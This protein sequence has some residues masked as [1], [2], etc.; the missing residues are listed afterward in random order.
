[1]SITRIGGRA[2]PPLLVKGF[3]TWLAYA[4]SGLVS[5]L[6]SRPS[7]IVIPLYLPAGF[8]LACVL[9]WGRWMVVPVGLGAATVMLLASGLPASPWPSWHVLVIM[10]FATCT[11]AGLQAWV[12]ARW[13]GVAPGAPLRLESPREI[14]RFM[15]L[16]GALACF[17]NA[18]IVT[19][20]QAIVSNM[21][22][23]DA[24]TMAASWWAGDALGV[25][26]GAPLML[27]LVG[28][29]A[30]LWRGRQR[31]VGIPLLVIT[32]LLGWTIREV[33]NWERERENSVFSRDTQS[34]GANVKA[35]LNGYLYALEALHGAA[36]SSDAITRQEFHTLSQFWLTSLAGVQAVGWSE[37]VAM[38]DLPAFER[39]QQASG[40]RQY[41][42]FN[43]P[44][45][46][47]PRDE[48]VA[49]RYIEPVS[50]NGAALGYNILSNQVARSTYEAARISDAPV[51]SPGLKLIQEIGQQTGVVLYK[52]VHAGQ[53][54]TTEEM[55]QSTKGVMFLTLRMD[56]M[57]KAS[58]AGHPAYLHTCVVDMTDQQVLGGESGCPGK[59]APNGR[60]PQHL[61][62]IDLTFANRPWHLVVWTNERPPLI[63]NLSWSWLV[64]V[65][66]VT[67]A[68]AL[69]S[70]LLVITGRTKRVEEAMAQA[71]QL[72]IAA[73]SANRAKSEFLSRMSH[74]LRTPLNA[75][76]GFA[77]VME[78]DQQTPLPAS[79]HNRL[80]QIQQAGWHLL[81]MIDDVLDLSRIDTGTIKL[82]PEEVAPDEVIESAVQM[83]QDAAQ[84][85]LVKIMPRKPGPAGWGI[86]ADRTR[87]RQ[88]LIN[89]LGNAIKYNRPNGLITISTSLDKA[90]DGSARYHMT[91]TDTGLGMS[92]AQQAQLFQPFNRL[93]REKMSADGVGIGLVISQHLA[94]MM[95]GDLS[96]HSVEG[97][98]SS[99]T[100][101]LPASALLPLTTEN[102]AMAP[103]LPAEAST[104]AAPPRA[105][106]EVL[107]VEDNP[108]N[109]ELVRN[110]LAS[111]PWIRLTIAKTGAAG[112]AA[113]LDRAKG[114]HPHLILLDM[115]L[116]DISGLELLKQV[117]STLS[118]AHVPVIV[119][120][121]DAMP[122][123]I[124]A[125]MVAGAT[126]YLTKPIHLPD[127][128][129]RLDE[130]LEE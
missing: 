91:V 21:P 49:I 39:A 87:V 105:P 27:T 7:D 45:V 16:A 47:P 12:G 54:I 71:R 66:G 38:E 15:L 125:A 98:G 10:C 44:Q 51:A 34:M 79:Q 73:E 50:I 116:P 109:A 74:E 119:I 113:V 23:D 101:S 93:G 96:F 128:L 78:L 126:A 104:D 95:N 63:D 52:A 18:L 30:D 123:R 88:I 35:R 36:V 60:Q 118:S 92:E 90:A 53:P 14:A 129:R 32:A 115:H 130:L 61:Q 111:R 99:F 1:M 48:V 86:H 121:A 28:Q 82:A 11:G 80:R 56:D 84:K 29:P 112:M 4:G 24:V 120:S 67:L 3:L 102:P 122:E 114:I 77:Q 17:I 69:A 22:F 68:A 20:V 97:N 89:L 100:L 127:L 107:Y 55:R 110:A 41:R 2:L 64:T 25:L 70:L 72:Q 117:K 6:L 81:E 37:R 108:A 33:Q 59:G 43:A 5:L 76:L 85:H 58:T 40:A 75:V 124:Q 26:I 62:T 83:V 9:G 19:S 106:K 94:R 57:I 8:A 46:H 65:G 13:S 42:V 103:A 31:L